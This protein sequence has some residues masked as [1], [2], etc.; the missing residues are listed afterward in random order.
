M[1][2]WWIV[3]DGGYYVYRIISI[4]ITGIPFV[5]CPWNAD[6]NFTTLWLDNHLHTPTVRPASPL[7]PHQPLPYCFLSFFAMR[8]SETNAAIFVVFAF[9]SH[10][11]SRLVT[12]GYDDDDDALAERPT[13]P[14]RPPRHPL[15][16]LVPLTLKSSHKLLLH[17]QRERESERE[18]KQIAR[19]FI[20]S[21]APPHQPARFVFRFSFRFACT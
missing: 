21:A 19:N 16:P 8:M 7:H 18:N 14:R 15:P 13:R 12:Q 3:G 5:Q 4:K 6:I 17:R 2:G 20:L 10:A 1:G 11:H 9:N